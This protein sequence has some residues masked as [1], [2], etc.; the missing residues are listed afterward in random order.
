MAYESYARSSRAS[1]AR[2]CAWWVS[3][4]ETLRWLDRVCQGQYLPSLSINYVAINND[5]KKLQP[6][7]YRIKM[8]LCFDQGY[9]DIG[10]VTATK[11]RHYLFYL[12]LYF[13]VRGWIKPTGGKFL[14][15]GDKSPSRWGQL[16]EP[17]MRSE[18]LWE[19][20][21]G[22][23]NKINFTVNFWVFFLLIFALFALKAH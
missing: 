12:W 19:S 9:N 10:V 3:V 5:L 1:H 8:K 18:E 23:E 20:L 17:E 15:A 6:Q 13:S 22:E 7:L 14:L 2:R 4:G 16:P 21:K 11:W